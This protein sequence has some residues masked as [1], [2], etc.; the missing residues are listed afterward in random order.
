MVSKKISEKTDNSEQ[1]AVLGAGAWGTAVSQLLADNGHEVLLWCYEP[2]VAQTIQNSR[3]NETYLS[4]VKLHERITATTDLS[5]IA[6]CS[7]VFE[8]I[9]VAFLRAVVQQAKN[10]VSPVATWVIL[11]KGIEH[12]TLMLPCAIV[13]DVMGKEVKVAVFA[14][15]T[16]AKELAEKQFTAT[17]LA[18]NDDCVL[19]ALYNLLANRYFR[20]FGTNDLIGAQVGG[21]IKNVLALAVG[22]A[23]GSGYK[24]N[25]VAYLLTRGLSEIGLLATHLGGKRETVYG[26]SG[27]GDM[28]LTCTGSLSK[29]LKAGRLVAQGSS[30]DD[31][32][33]IFK[34]LPEGINTV[35]SVQQLTERNQF[36]APLCNAVYEIIFHK[37]PVT[38][39]F[40]V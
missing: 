3:I 40:E 37:K 26:L 15:P 16:F 19:Q 24:D 27:L 22:L 23:H 32:V 29:N 4:G 39:L 13:Q 17:A 12:D 25:T 14:G 7:W 6:S 20:P 9:P 5:Q 31:L 18:S 28:I 1:I 35:Q 21:A 11:S 2:L 36:Q 8:A 30:L 10:F 34:T 33:T 38:F